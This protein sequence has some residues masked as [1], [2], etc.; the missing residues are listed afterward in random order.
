MARYSGHPKVFQ[1]FE[2]IPLSKWAISRSLS[3]KSCGIL[4]RMGIVAIVVEDDQLM[5]H[6]LSAALEQSGVT[7]VGKTGLAGEA[8]TLAKAHQPDVA[9]LDLHLGIGPT[10]LDVAQAIR[11]I[12]PAIGIVFLTSYDD[13]RLLNPSLPPLPVG[14]VYL[15]K[16]SVPDIEHLIEA[17]D[18]TIQASKRGEE[19]KAPVLSSLSDVQIET[20]RLVAQG[21]SNSEIAKQRFVTEKSVEVTVGRIIKSLGIAKG[22]TQNQRVHIVKVY[23]RALGLEANEST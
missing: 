16:R 14:S 19:L 23:Y 9:L 17:V 1:P 2:V 10:G 13:P 18:A 8:V 12:N 7:V 5:L 22:S 3:Y 4:E 21:L 15:T 6:S 20:M 11:R